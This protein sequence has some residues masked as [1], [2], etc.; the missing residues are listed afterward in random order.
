MSYFKKTKVILLCFLFILTFYSIYKY[1]YKPRK[2]IE[3]L[4]INYKGKSTD[5]L[6]IASN[7]FSK[8]NSKIVELSGKVS[9]LGNKGIIINRQIFCQFKNSHKIKTINLNQNITIK[10]RVIGYD[11]LLEELKLNQ[12][13]LK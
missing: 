2:T 4:S 11:D 7:D 1:S 13:I 12:C 10:G 8:W 9:E 6:E 3:E 5:F